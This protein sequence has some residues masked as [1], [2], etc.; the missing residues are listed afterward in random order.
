M[1]E[2]DKIVIDLGCNDRHLIGYK[3]VIR[4][5]CIKVAPDI[6]VS[7][8]NRPPL[9]F[10][11]NFTDEIHCYHVLEHLERP[12]D[13]LRE[14]YRIGKNGSDVFIGVPHF[15]APVAY[16]DPSHKHRFSLLYFYYFGEKF[17]FEDMFGVHS[18]KF[19][20]MPTTFLR[21]KDQPE[22]SLFKRILSK[23]LQFIP[24]S[25]PP[26]IADRFGPFFGGYHEIFVHLKIIK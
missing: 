14:I 23:V 11:D 21:Y 12:V 18:V 9:P 22:P 13:L 2:V 4:V 24:N 19:I 3:S 10:P 26:L 5:D 15:S 20:V 17:S 1:S 8:F 6:I 16:G 7:D 25:I